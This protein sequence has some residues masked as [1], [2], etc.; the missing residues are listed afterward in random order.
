M[1]DYNS[2]DIATAVAALAEMLDEIARADTSR[3]I[4]NYVISVFP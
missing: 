3:T 4:P 2:A 1:N